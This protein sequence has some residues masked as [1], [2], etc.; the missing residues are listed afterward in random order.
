MHDELAGKVAIVT[1]GSSGIG[2]GTAQRL[3]AEGASVVIADIDG[4]RGEEEAA[5]LGEHAA[6]KQ[7]D[8]AQ[9]DEV[10]LLVDFTTDRF[11]RLDI[12]FNNAGISGARK[13]VLIEG[14]FADFHHVLGVNLLGVLA[15]TAH[16]ARA[17]AET[18]GG[19]V[20]NNASI[21]GVQ[22]TRG[23]WA[24]N[25]SKAAVIHF[26]KSAAIELGGLGVRVNCIAPGNIETEILGRMLGSDL[27]DDERAAM[28]ERVRS[29]LMG[30]QP[31]QLQGTPDDIAEAVLFLGTDRSRY[32][33]GT[34]IP[35]DG[36]QLAGNPAASAE[37][38]SLRTSESDEESAQD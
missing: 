29:Y 28:M 27:P 24:Y 7:T 35:V 6:F 36:G 19:S 18:G 31:I 30:R 23:Q 13:P 20:I 12:M 16:A 2:L 9:P 33:T 4:P 25:S 32:I 22:P 15:G 3:V 8:V 17:M 5:A 11:G 37:F 14:D 10:A 26:T 38:R 34:V 1:G 21:G